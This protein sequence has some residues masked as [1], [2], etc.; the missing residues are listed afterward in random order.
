MNK[1]KKENIFI[2][3]ITISLFIIVIGFI[4]QFDILTGIGI[5]FLLFYT[6][7][8][9][10]FAKEIE[11]WDVYQF[12]NHKKGIRFWFIICLIPGILFTLA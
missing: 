3:S 11:E 10:F 5:F 4:M 1:K 2:A 9:M 7:L 8:G 6:G 12:E